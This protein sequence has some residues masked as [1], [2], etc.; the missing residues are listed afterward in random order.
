MRFIGINV[1]ILAFP[2]AVIA[3]T[4]SRPVAVIAHDFTVSLIRDDQHVLRVNGQIYPPIDREQFFSPRI[5]SRNCGDVN[6]AENV[7]FRFRIDGVRFGEANQQIFWLDVQDMVHASLGIPIPPSFTNFCIGYNA[8]LT[9]NVESIIYRVT[10]CG[11]ESLILNPLDVGRYALDR[12]IGYANMDE[13][14]SCVFAST[15][16]DDSVVE[17]IGAGDTTHRLFIGVN[18]D[19]LSE[20]SESAFRGII[21]QIR[22]R[23][24]TFVQEQQM[25]LVFSPNCYAL[26]LPLL[27]DLKFRIAN[28]EGGAVVTELI[29]S[30]HDYFGP[31]E[32]PNVCKLFVTQARNRG[33]LVLTDHLIK[34]IGGIHFD[35]IHN[36]I[37]F[38]DPL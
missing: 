31:S 3:T 20:I 6:H 37:G 21:Y 7:R 22:A 36:R 38:F 33:S 9:R 8:Q 4:V 24:G 5:V 14:R 19:G 27:P 25:G 1:L 17:P 12:I 23:G 2:V 10:G 32:D 15:H 18:D 28:E 13:N 11:D 34:A 16:L 26:Y 29:F 35:Y 30:P